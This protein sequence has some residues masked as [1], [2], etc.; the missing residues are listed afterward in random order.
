M[1]VLKCAKVQNLRA[2]HFESYSS[3]TGLSSP[4]NC[5]T[6]RSKRYFFGGSFVLF[7][8]WVCHAFASAHCYCVVICWERADLLALIC[9]V[10]LCGCYFPIWYP[11]SGVVLDCINS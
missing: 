7:L 9:G 5:F 1:L 10:K 11:G 2:G 4:V 8:H 6:D 3:E